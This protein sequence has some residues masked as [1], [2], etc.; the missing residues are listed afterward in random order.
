MRVLDQHLVTGM[1]V[2]PVS[3]DPITTFHFTIR[4]GELNTEAQISSAL[5]R[6]IRHSF[7]D[8]NTC[9]QRDP[10]PLSA[11]RTSCSGHADW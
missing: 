3:K 1:F 8:R 11:R 10:E 7:R 6:L 4:R 2:P 5:E 9:R